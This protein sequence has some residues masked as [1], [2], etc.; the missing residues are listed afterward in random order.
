MN[1]ADLEMTDV[2][3]LVRARL[4]L[5]ATVDD[6]RAIVGRV[7]RAWIQS[8]IERTVRWADLPESLRHHPLVAPA[9][10]E[11]APNHRFSTNRLPKLEPWING[12]ILIGAMLFGT[13]L[14]GDG[15]PDPERGIRCSEM[16]ND[17]IVAA[18]IHETLGLEDQFSGLLS[19]GW[20]RVDDRYLLEEFGPGV[21][22]HVYSV[23]EHVER[24]DRAFE[25]GLA[26]ELEVPAPYANVL[27]A[28]EAARLRLTARAAGDRMFSVLDEAKRSELLRRGIDCGPP[29]SEF[30]ERP[31]LE[32][33]HL[34]ASAAIRLP[35]IDK[36]TLRI[37]VEE[38]LLQS[39]D[40]VLNRGLPPE[41]LVGRYGAAVYQFHTALPL[42]Y[43]YSPINRKTTRATRGQTV[44]VEGPFALGTLHLSGLEAAR[45]LQQVRRKANG[46]SAAHSFVVAARAEQV[47]H[48]HRSV[49]IIAGSDCHDVVEDGGLAVTGYDQT[50]EMFASRFGSPLAALVAE[51][52]DSITKTDGPA[53]AATFRN[54]AHLPTAAELYN[55][56]QFD[57]L[58]AVATDPKVPYTVAGVVI[59]LADTGTTQDEGI[60]D[61]D[62]MTGIWRH[63]GARVSWDQYSR[64]EIVRPLLDRLVTEIRV[65]DADPFYHRKTGALSQPLV[66]RLKELIGWFLT[67]A[68]QYMV[69][70]LTILAH[71]YRLPEVEQGDLVTRF[72]DAAR[73]RDEM[74]EHLDSILI[75]SALD[76]EVRERGLAAGYRMKVDG[77]VGRDLTQLLDY[78][79]SALWRA[80][81]R[82]S[83]GMASPA[84]ELFDEVVRLYELRV[85]SEPKPSI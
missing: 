63:S 21:V 77:T 85:E 54:Q 83:L 53:K 27:A 7:S 41:Q 73:T 56:G 4:L 52:T 22:D 75:D 12:S 78:R 58:R 60:R 49:P 67:T 69:Q 3:R 5:A 55:V 50:L 76:E 59:K 25:A 70:N 62:M 19:S 2:A 65:S 23:R 47:L 43:R 39:T 37:P 48:S 10:T 15:T 14:Y 71:E 9:G 42:L 38:Q 66:V 11:P 28:I 18:M 24:F 46:T 74:A 33:D 64:G 17:L 31:H 81:L 13:R 45:Y 20:R 35:G 6:R 30:P 72:F 16:G 32:R 82:G 29:G 51:V 8:E 44:E 26:E 1:P 57:E 84:P 79:D 34:R 36:S 68:D 80:R 61:P 40:N